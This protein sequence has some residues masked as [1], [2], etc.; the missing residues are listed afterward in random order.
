MKGLKLADKDIYNQILLLNMML[1]AELDPESF[2]AQQLDK[3]LPFQGAFPNELLYLKALQDLQA[4]NTEAATLKFEFLSTANIHF[5][6]GLIASARF[7]SAD[8]TDRLK[9]YSIIVSGILARPNSIKLLKA[10]VKEAA[11]IGFDDEANESLEKLKR[12]LPP[13]AFNA[14]IAENPNFFDI[15]K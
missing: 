15:E 13:R 14:Y 9:S 5:E 4:G 11:L 3:A 10:Y 1:L 8:T 7:F 6:E 12:L 2:N